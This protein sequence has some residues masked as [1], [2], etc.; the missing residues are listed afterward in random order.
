MGAKTPII[1][2][3]SRKPPLEIYVSINY[4]LFSVWFSFFFNWSIVDLGFPGGS[5]GKESTCNAWD[6]GLIPGLGRPPGGERGKLLQSSCLE[7]LC[8]QRSL[9]VYSP[10][11][12]KEW[13]TTEWLSTAHTWNH[14]LSQWPKR[15]SATRD[16]HETCNSI[17]Y[18]THL[19][20]EDMWVLVYKI[21]VTFCSYFVLGQ[22]KEN[23]TLY[24]QIK[25]FKEDIC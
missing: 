12:R 7:N 17:N 9:A 8:G 15:I 19:V 16:P 11:G 18:A 5:D 3:T 2:I 24:L 14:L 22:R 25:F 4:I 20:F 23:I 10:W 13:D 1:Q 21:S 6:L